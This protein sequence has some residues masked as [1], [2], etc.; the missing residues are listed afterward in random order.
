MEIYKPTITLTSAAQKGM[1]VYVINKSDLLNVCSFIA[2]ISRQME[3]QKSPAE[4]L[5]L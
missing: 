4:D 1:V 3:K 2:Q 5:L